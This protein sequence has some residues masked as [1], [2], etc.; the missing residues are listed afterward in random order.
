MRKWVAESS[1]EEG[2]GTSV[3][4]SGA[5]GIDGH[6]KGIKD[7]KSREAF[8]SKREIR[9]ANCRALIE[10]DEHLREMSTQSREFPP[11]VEV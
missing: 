7:C 9:T 1:L 11:A 4:I 5:A 2:V 10:I 8:Q 6:T 3:L